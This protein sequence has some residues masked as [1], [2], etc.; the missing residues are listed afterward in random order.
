MRTTVTLDEDVV[1]MIKQVMHD[2][3]KSFKE[4]V[5]DL[6][7]RGSMPPQ[8]RRK[9]FV[10]RA[11]HMPFKPGIDT[12]KLADLADELEIEEFVNKQTKRRAS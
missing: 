10:V 9:P 8:S 2:Q 7:R 1:R 6:I 5:N 3:K 12:A 4:A 11:R